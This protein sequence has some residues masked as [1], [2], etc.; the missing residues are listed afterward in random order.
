MRGPSGIHYPVGAIALLEQSGVRGNMAIHFDWGEYALWHLGPRVKVSMDGRR[1]TVYSEDVYQMH[2]DFTWGRGDWD[3]L[4]RTHETHLVLVSKKH[5]AFNL[6]RLEPGWSSI[7]DDSVSGLF[8]LEGWHLAE[9]LEPLSG[10]APEND[11]V[12]LCF[13]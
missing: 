1:E 4:L 2:L 6:M 9:Q 11:D 5:P 10:P 7:Y 12:N 13:P 8:V 3:A